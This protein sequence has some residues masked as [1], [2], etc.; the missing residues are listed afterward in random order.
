MHELTNEVI[1]L[2]DLLAAPT[3]LEELAEAPDWPARFAR[4]DGELA[5]RLDDAPAPHPGVRAACAQLAATGGTTPVGQLAAEL[6]WSRRHLGARFRDEVG[7]A[8]KTYARLVRFERAAALLARPEPDLADV[9]LE[10]RLLRPGALQPRVPRF[11]GAAPRPGRLPRRAP[12]AHPSKTRWRSRPSLARMP[13]IFP[14]PPLQRRRRRARLAHGT[15]SASRSTASTAATTARSSTAS[16]TLGDAWLMIGSEPEGGD[17]RF[18][19]RAG[20]AS[21]TSPSPDAAAVFERAKAAGADLTC[22]LEA[23]DYGGR[24]FGLRDPE[25]NRWSV[26]EYDPSS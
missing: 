8:P 25:G 3:L 12:R 11:A 24:E 18:G 4:L 26:G 9:A 10:L 2:E 5:R 7:V 15:C 1:P 6:G 17:E 16:C 19:R 22:E 13:T 23:R 14:D 21:S 20:R